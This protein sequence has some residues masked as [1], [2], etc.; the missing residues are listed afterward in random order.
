MLSSLVTHPFAQENHQKTG[1]Y[2]GGHHHIAGFHS[3]FV[4]GSINHLKPVAGT[5]VQTNVSVAR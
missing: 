4:S 3:D 5:G 1:P 2:C